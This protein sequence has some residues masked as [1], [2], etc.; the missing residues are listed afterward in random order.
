MTTALYASLLATLFVA[1]SYNVIRNRQTQKIALG[2]G[3]KEVM[4]KAMR[5]HGNFSEYTPFFLILLGL[6][7]Y[8][9]LPAWAVHSL[10]LLFL[11]GRLSHAYGVAFREKLE[12]DRLENIVFRVR[13]MILTFTAILLCAGIALTQYCVALLG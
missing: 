11:A 3:G 6:V 10:G 12:D 1:L 5:A 9:G 8:Q 7:E 13:G 2:D 4:R